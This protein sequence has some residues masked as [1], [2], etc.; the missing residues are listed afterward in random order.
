MVAQGLRALLEPEFEVIDVVAR[1]NEVPAA[2]ARLR[3]DV[4]LLDLTLPGRNGIDLMPD[5]RRRTPETRILVVTM[6]ADPVLARAAFAAGALGF[7]PKDCDVEELRE[8]MT[9]VLAG[10]QFL[11][12]RIPRRPEQPPPSPA[13]EAFWQLT[14]RQREILKAVGEGKSTEEIANQLGLSPHTVHFHRRRM[15]KVLGIDT[16]DGLLRFAVMMQLVGP[17]RTPRAPRSPAG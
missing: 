10:R 15:R 8:A 6:H 13:R 5:I 14:P 17:T 7:M 4:L 3:P 1:G 2:C 12:G 16:E 9:E 11:S